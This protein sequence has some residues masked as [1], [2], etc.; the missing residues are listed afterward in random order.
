[1]LKEMH[2]KK[3]LNLVLTSRP[4]HFFFEEG[5]CA[6]AASVDGGCEPDPAA[7]G[8]LEVG[9]VNDRGSKLDE[10]RE[11]SEGRIYFTRINGDI[12]PVGECTRD[13]L[14]CVA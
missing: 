10:E 12:E 11:I 3:D 14:D 6:V 13:T 9:E 5:A 8:V 2:L 4:F 1:M 7:C